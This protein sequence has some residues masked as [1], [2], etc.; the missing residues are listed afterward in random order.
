M[1]EYLSTAKTRLL[2]TG[3]HNMVS[4]AYLFFFHTIHTR[5]LKRLARTSAYV[6]RS[7][8]VQHMFLLFRGWGEGGGGAL[9][10]EVTCFTQRGTRQR[11]LACFSRVRDRKR[12]RARA[13]AFRWS[14]RLLSMTNPRA[15]RRKKQNEKK[16]RSCLKQWETTGETEGRRESTSQFH[17]KPFKPGV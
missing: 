7:L 8:N 4:S 10:V 11:K 6:K 13:G 15:L 9:R 12:A 16:V 5:L 14:C 3:N 2:I 1:T 17:L